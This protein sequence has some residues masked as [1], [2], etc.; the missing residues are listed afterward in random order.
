MEQ[1]NHIEFTT[2]RPVSKTVSR[3]YKHVDGISKESTR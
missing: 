2:E 3:P 1:V